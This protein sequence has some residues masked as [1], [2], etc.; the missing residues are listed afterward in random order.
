MGLSNFQ[1]TFEAQNDEIE[2]HHHRK[3]R[4]GSTQSL[5]ELD[6]VK[7]STGVYDNYGQYDT[8][9]NPSATFD[10]NLSL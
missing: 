10:K 2:D 1:D 4:Q 5:L 8:R 6:L 3:P 7:T 9:P